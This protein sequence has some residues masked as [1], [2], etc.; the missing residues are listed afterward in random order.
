M[1][2]KVTVSSFIHKQY[3][4]LISVDNISYIEPYFDS[5]SVNLNIENKSVIYFKNKEGS[6]VVKESLDELDSLINKN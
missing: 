1:F 2:I 3:N 6:L 5:D 4:K